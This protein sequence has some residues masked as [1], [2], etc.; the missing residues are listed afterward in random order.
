M[1]AC[2]NAPLPIWRST[3]G[4]S[5]GSGYGASSVGATRRQK[6]GRPRSVFALVLAAAAVAG[7]TGA[8]LEA[9]VGSRSPSLQARTNANRIAR[10]YAETGSYRSLTKIRVRQ[11]PSTTAE[12]TGVI[13]DRGEVFEV[14]D[15][16]QGGDSSPSYLK[17][18]AKNGEGWVFDLGIAGSFVGKPIVERLASQPADAAPP[19]AAPPAVEAS[20][21]AAAPIPTA[22][23]PSAAPAAPVVVEA[24]V[25]GGSSAPSPAVSAE[26]LDVSVAIGHGPVVTVLLPDTVLGAGFE[27][28]QVDVQGVRLNLMLGSGFA[29]NALTTRGFEMVS[30]VIQA[31][32]FTGGWASQAVKQAAVDLEGVKIAA[33]GAFIGKI[34]GFETFDFPQ[35]QLAGQL[36]MEVHGML[37]A[38]FFKEFDM[39]H[40]RYGGRANFYAPGGAAAEGFDVAVK[41]LPG[42]ELPSGNIGITVRAG[43]VAEGKEGEEVSFLGLVDTSAAYTV[44]NWEAAKL[45]GFEGKDDSTL[46]AATRVLGAGL[47]GEPEEMPVISYRLS[48]CGMHE[49]VRMAVKGL[50]KEKFEAQDQKG[51]GWSLG[52][53]DKKGPGRVDFGAVNVAIGDSINFGVLDHPIAGGFTGPVA[54]VGQDLLFQAQRVVI[55]NAGAQIWLEPGEIKDMP[56]M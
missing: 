33:T 23:I 1:T 39:D 10:A 35:A 19:A 4:G 6:L 13:L 5:S 51:D 44:L 14:V 26:P 47:T 37:G 45:L 25:E 42:L 8:A 32:E 36:G 55:N 18:K 3:E 24:E 22:P 52:D 9:F 30:S 53:I 34:E 56:D 40:D 49:S 31:P 38:P 27:V 29:A 50:S 48:L 46:A 28:M 12:P 16:V 15:V 2:E 54:V 7:I 41:H 43:S 20:M 11:E 17:I 21:P